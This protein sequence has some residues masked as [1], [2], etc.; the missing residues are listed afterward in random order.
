MRKLFFLCL[1]L[2]SISFLSISTFAQATGPAKNIRFGATDPATCTANIGQVF[3]N[4]TTDQLK[5]CTASN[6]WTALAAGAGSGDFVG[7]GSSTDN[8]I[9]RFDGTTGK[10]GQN[11]VVL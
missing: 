7:P 9:V 11:S 2:F 10:V 3:F 1:I 6:T 5:I 8:A 4:T